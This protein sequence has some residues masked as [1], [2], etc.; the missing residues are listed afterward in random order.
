MRAVDEV[1]GGS[2][3]GPEDDPVGCR[4]HARRTGGETWR[5]AHRVGM[6]LGRSLLA[7]GSLLLFACEDQLFQNAG[8]GEPVGSAV[9][10]HGGMVPPDAGPPA[11][12]PPAGSSRIAFVSERDGNREIYIV[13]ADG[14]GLVRLTNE[15]ANDDAPAWSPDGSR[16]AFVS[17]RSGCGPDL[18]VMNADG[19]H[20]VRRTFSGSYT[21]APAWSPDGTKIVYS[22]VSDGSA[23]LWSVHPDDGAPSLLCAAPGWDS[24]PAWSPDGTRL[25]L[26]SDWLAYDSVYDIHLI[27]ADGSGFTA[28]TGNIFDYVDY[29][30]SSWSRDGT[31]IAVKITRT[32]GIDQYVTQLGVMRPDG[33]GLTPLISAATWA[34]SSWSPDGKRIAFTSGVAGQ[35]S[36]SWVMADGSG[37]GTIITNGWD[38][39]WH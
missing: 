8:A 18:Y 12:P 22:A 13:N 17:D 16:I 20:V 9:R 25:A 2:L 33:S 3:R 38:P 7:V 37:S 36:I 26:V 32:V 21:E 11:P 1:I 34:R 27:N 31:K 19:S 30:R 4:L 28:L 10:R 14:T 15:P 35:L 39:D 23:N 24:Q 29:L 6:A 5:A